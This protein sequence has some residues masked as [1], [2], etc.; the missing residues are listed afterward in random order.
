M[1]LKEKDI[2]LWMDYTG[3]GCRCAVDTIS[4]WVPLFNNVASA[5][6]LNS[7]E[8]GLLNYVI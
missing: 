2:K 5:E 4:F 6:G 1:D 8:L 3:T 7:M